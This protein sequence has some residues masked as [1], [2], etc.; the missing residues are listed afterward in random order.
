M[1]TPRHVAIIMDGNGR[2]AKQR[3]LPRFMGHRAGGKVVQKIVERAVEAGVEVLTLFAFSL[4]NHARPMSEV[5]YL[6][7]LFIDYLDRYLQ[8]LQENKVSLRIIGDRN[9]FNKSLLNK[10]EKVEQS[11]QQDAKMT[12]VLAIHYSGRWDITQAMQQ[13]AHKIEQGSLMAAEITPQLINKHLN[14]SDLP[15]PD[16]L[17]RTSGEQRISN[18]MLWQFAYTELFFSSMYWPDFSVQEFDRAL[19]A[20]AGR[21]RRFGLT[22]EQTEAQHA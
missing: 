1:K 2:W 14:L 9:Y 10:I 6:M 4:E 13:I 11:T 21:E 16:L 7:T 20:F 3:K 18:F 5:D 8:K 12:L 15:E 19:A 22:P 17:I